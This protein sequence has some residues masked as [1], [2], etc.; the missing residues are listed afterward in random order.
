MT[1]IEHMRAGGLKSALLVSGDG[2]FDH[3]DVA[4]RLHG[5]GLAVVRASDFG[6]AIARMKDAGQFAAFAAL[7]DW[8]RR[9]LELANGRLN[10][11]WENI[12]HTMTIPAKPVFSLDRHEPTILRVLDA[13]PLR[14]SSAWPSTEPEPRKPGVEFASVGIEVELDVVARYTTQAIL[15]NRTEF[16]LSA[17]R[18]YE[19]VEHTGYGRTERK[20]TLTRTVFVEAE[21]KVEDGSLVDIAV[22]DGP[23]S[24]EKPVQRGPL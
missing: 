15:L 13:R 7:G 12:R 14:V 21:I 1:L 6:D 17:E 20:T 9:V 24:G 5:H 10:D 4:A 11:I 2:V 23:A 8:R 18:E 16:S 22:R 19:P 3:Q